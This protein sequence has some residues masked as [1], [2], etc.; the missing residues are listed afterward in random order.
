MPKK[1]YFL[2]CIGL[3]SLTVFAQKPEQKEV[4]I[5]GKILDKET[6]QPLEYATIAFF[7][8]LQNNNR[9]YYRFWREF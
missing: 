9:W 3:F 6:N 4:I 2:I 1:L 8:K 7:N 5:T